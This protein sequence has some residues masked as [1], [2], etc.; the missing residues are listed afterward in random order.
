MNVCGREGESKVN[1]EQLLME[2]L[3]MVEVAVT[4]VVL[5]VVVVIVV[6]EMVLVQDMLVGSE[7]GTGE[8][9]L[10]E[11]A[12]CIEPASSTDVGTRVDVRTSDETT[13]VAVVVVI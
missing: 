2:V 6:V 3:V 11:A 12:L 5:V 7:Q 8:P 4:V 10:V 9:P 13:V 1:F